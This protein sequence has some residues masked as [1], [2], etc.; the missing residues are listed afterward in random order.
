MC[1]FA[2]NWC[3]K[4]R[5]FCIYSSKSW[6][7]NGLLVH[8]AHQGNVT[9]ITYVTLR[10][11]ISYLLTACYCPQTPFDHIW[12]MVWSGARGNIAI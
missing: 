7:Y 4:L 1:R 10:Y 2:V 3:D 9:Y 12:A 11:F 5:F 8:P 6:K